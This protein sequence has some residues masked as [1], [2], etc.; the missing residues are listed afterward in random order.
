VQVRQGSQ[1]KRKKEEGIAFR[2]IPSSLTP[3]CFAIALV[4]CARPAPP[5]QKH[6]VVTWHTLGSWSGRGNT[7]TESFNSEGGLRVQWETRRETKPGT[8][9]FKVTIHSAISGRPI[10]VIVDRR[11]PGADTSYLT[12]DPRTYYAVVEASNIDWSITIQEAVSGTVQP[13]KP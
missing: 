13:P 1:G 2:F 10:G 7:Q 12:D 9:A 5:A 4:S 6:D 3:V 8:G 11:G